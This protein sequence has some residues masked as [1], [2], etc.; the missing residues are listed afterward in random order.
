LSARS[1]FFDESHQL[2]QIFEVALEADG[3]QHLSGRPRRFRTAADFRRSHSCPFV[4]RL[5]VGLVSGR[6][7]MLRGPAVVG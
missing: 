5:A 2:L 4:V 6:V 1:V 3:P 7:P